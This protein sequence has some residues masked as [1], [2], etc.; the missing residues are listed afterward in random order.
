VRTWGKR[1]M[2]TEQ[3]HH[4]GSWDIGE[5]R[6]TIKSNRKCVGFPSFHCFLSDI[7]DSMSLVCL[8]QSRPRI[9]CSNEVPSLCLSHNKTPVCPLWSQITAVGRSA[10]WMTNCHGDPTFQWWV[11]FKVPNSIGMS[12]KMQLL[13]CIMADPPDGR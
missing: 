3:R 7:Q 9:P 4:W 11:V 1:N 12:Y 13:P 2:R 8:L 6:K 5:E 10:S